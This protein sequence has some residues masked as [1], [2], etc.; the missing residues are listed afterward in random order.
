MRRVSD[1]YTIVEVMIFLAISLFI[2]MAS[3]SLISGKQAETDFNQKMRDTQSKLQDWMNDV[4]T[5]F[6]GADPSQQ[7]CSIVGG[8]PSIQTGGPS[9]TPQCV[10]LGKAI[11]FT[12][13]PTNPTQAENLYTYS[14]FGCRLADCPNTPGP[15]DSSPTDMY[16]S[17]PKAADGISSLDLTETFS[18]A[19]AYVKWVC[20]VGACTSQP[21]Q[22]TQSH[23]IGFFNSLNTQNSGTSN[24]AEDL[25]V[26][27]F[28]I[29]GDF[30]KNSSQV[31]DCLKL[32]GLC[33]V[34]PPI[35]NPPALNKYVVCLS[36]GKRTAE[37]SI[38]SSGG[39]GAQTNLNYV[40]C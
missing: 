36:D 37:I 30:G 25:N 12:D 24:G 2:A 14:V 10:F 39:V 32:L 22:S 19:P 17:K 4:S 11:Q 1:G 34:T 16:H 28:T 8:R 21:S 26:Y 15:T 3:W 35:L 18:L 29:P 7:N 31:D 5:G 13:F 20:S 9:T 27:Q 33:N 6:T 40:S 23:V 38:V